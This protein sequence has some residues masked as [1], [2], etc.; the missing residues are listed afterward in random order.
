LIRKATRVD[1]PRIMEIRAAVRENKLRDPSR[2]TV[3]DVYWFIDNPGIFVWE[4]DG[5]IVGFS[6]ADQRSGSIFALRGRGIGRVLFERACNVLIDA[7]CPRMWLTT[8][9]GTR[10]ERFYRKAGWRVTGID[11][12]NLV[13]EK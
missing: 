10:A 6:A 13:F 7:G 1:V 4:E 2:V 8:W 12:G 5:G 9:P 11:D 3:E